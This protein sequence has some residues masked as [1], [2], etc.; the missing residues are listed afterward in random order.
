MLRR[1]GGAGGR[2]GFSGNGAGGP[3]VAIAYT[4][5]AVV[6]TPDSHTTA[7]TPGAGVPARTN[8]TTNVTIPA[9]ASGPAMAILAF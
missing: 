3:S 2:A 4:G 5:G 9:S 8:P 1:G 7:G 6:V